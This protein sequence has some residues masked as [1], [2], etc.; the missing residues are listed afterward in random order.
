[1]GVLA[2][3]LTGLMRPA[4]TVVVVDDPGRAGSRLAHALAA[5]WNVGLLARLPKPPRPEPAPD[6]GV[7]WPGVVVGVVGRVTPWIC[8]QLR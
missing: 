5:A 6:D 7:V 1:M 8:R 2:E 3:A 4:G